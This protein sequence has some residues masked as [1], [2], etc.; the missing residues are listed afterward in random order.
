MISPAE[1][2]VIASTDD[3]WYGRETAVAN[4]AR[5]H[6]HRHLDWPQGLIASDRA[7]ESPEAF[8]R[9]VAFQVARSLEILTQPAITVASAGTSPP[10]GVED[11]PAGVADPQN[12][13][14]AEEPP[15]ADDGSV[16]QTGHHVFRP[17]S[18]ISR[19]RAKNRK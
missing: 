8:R 12:L 1:G 13:P 7:L 9:Y 2:V 11:S 6:H 19:R 4:D 14:P 3:L 17:T 16:R 15:G 10:A 18:R 5:H